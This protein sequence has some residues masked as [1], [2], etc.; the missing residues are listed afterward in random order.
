MLI[1]GIQLQACY[2]SSTQC[3]EKVP[4]LN[5]FRDPVMTACHLALFLSACFLPLGWP[6]VAFEFFDTRC[7]SLILFRA[8]RIRER[9]LRSRVLQ[10]FGCET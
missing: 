6:P 10:R 9:S 5:S 8:G 7:R 4:D 2:V 1:G 3:L